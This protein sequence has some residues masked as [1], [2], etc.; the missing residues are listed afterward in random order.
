LE[1]LPYLQHKYKLLNILYSVIKLLKELHGTQ[2]AGI[3]GLFKM[4]NLRIDLFLLAFDKQ[5]AFS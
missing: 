2:N 1:G 4:N 3:S 5:L